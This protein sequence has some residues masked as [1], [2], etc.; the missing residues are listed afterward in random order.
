MPTDASERA[1]A[2]TKAHADAVAKLAKA[3]DELAQAESEAHAALV[4]G[5]L[6]DADKHRGTVAAARL[7]LQSAE[8][9]EEALRR[10]QTDVSAEVQRGQVLSQRDQLTD[11]IAASTDQV[12]ELVT[13]ARAALR[14]ARDKLMQAE[15]IEPSLAAMQ[16]DLHQIRVE[17]G[18]VPQSITHGRRPVSELFDRLPALR[19][20][21]GLRTDDI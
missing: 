18:E 20:I 11:A 12:N 7:A 16:R 15:S 17:L 2:L 8:A 13:D 19:G 1:A 14:V 21:S 3:R 4:A 5:Q 6:N 9:T 10:A